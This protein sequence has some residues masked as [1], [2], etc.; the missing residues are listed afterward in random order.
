MIICFNCSP[1]TKK[2]LDSLLESGQY[3]DY[4]DIISLAIE[5]LLVIQEEILKSGSHVIETNSKEDL[6]LFERPS[7]YSAKVSNEATQRSSD[8]AASFSV[9][10]IFKL[11]DLEGS[12][13][14]LAEPPDDVWAIGQEVL[15]DRWIFGQYNRLLP[16]KASCR[17][18]LRLLLKQPK[19]ILVEEG[20][21]RI[22]KEAVGLGDFL[23]RHDKENRISR[24]DALSTAFPSTGENSDKSRL[25]FEN[26]FVAG[27][28]RQGQ[29]SGLLMDLKLINGN[30]R[31]STGLM[32]TEVGWQFATLPNPILDN[33]QEAPTDKFSEDEKQLLI[34]HIA[35]SVPVEHFA[36]RVILRKILEGANTPETVDSAL[37]EYAPGG[38]NR[39]LSK[40]FLASQR[41]G[42]ISRMADLGLVKR[43][44]DGVRVFYVVTEIGMKFV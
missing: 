16:A 43:A 13:P 31:K 8:R 30:G 14:P 15:I 28:N 25:R 24:D 29:I 1:E 42:A 2:A 4:G 33:F 37:L 34:N 19:G 38:K 7:A 18:L 41:S 11:D 6:R 9:P 20:S 32:L 44:R 12:S 39:S 35:E 17:A 10:T 26:Q 5:N 23:V 21:R 36:Y 40:S 27:V 3:E 22:A